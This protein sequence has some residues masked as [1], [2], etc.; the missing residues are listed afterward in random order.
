[1]LRLYAQSGASELTDV[2][3]FNEAIDEALTESMD[4][5]ADQTDQFRD[6][7]I[8][9]LSHDLRTPLGVVTAGAALLALPEHGA[10]DWRSPRRD[11]RSF[12]RIDAAQAMA[13]RS[14]TVVRRGDD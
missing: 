4:R 11:P 1:V 5:F 8:G 3:R 6:Q 13:S 14:A 7:F 9:V 2:L 12:G 10:D